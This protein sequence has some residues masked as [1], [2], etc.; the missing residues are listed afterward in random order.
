[1]KFDWTQGALAEGLRL[2]DAAEFFAAHEAWESVWLPAQEPE[3]T[4]LQGLIQVT[5]AFHHLRRENRL[6]TS[7]LLRAALGR[8][9][10]YPQDFGG[11]SVDLLRD[12]IRVW[13]Q[14]LEM[15]APAPQPGVARIK[16]LE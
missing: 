5:A 15:D 12:D 7:R 2:Y 6:G 11:I 8:L 3:K 4:F 10:L 16:C 14:A 1:M 13:L 9:E